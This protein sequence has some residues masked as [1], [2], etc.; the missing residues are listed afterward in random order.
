M[1]GEV[2]PQMPLV[3]AGATLP[4]GAV[5]GDEARRIFRNRRQ[6]EIAA[7]A[8]L[9][10]FLIFTGFDFFD[11]PRRPGKL[12]RCDRVKAFYGRMPFWTIS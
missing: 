12:M 9:P 3:L 4:T 11:R 7:E 2:M 6:I 8:L 10:T 5:D 1:L